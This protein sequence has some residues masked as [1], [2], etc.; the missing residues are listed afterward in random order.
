MSERLSLPVSEIGER[1]GAL[2]L[3]KPAAVAAMASSLRHY[4]QLS[5]VVVCPHLAEG[6]EL[7]DGFKRL[8][9][10]RRMTELT[11]LQARVLR[12]D[13]R[14]A[15]A[16]VVELNRTGGRL[17]EFEEALVVQSLYR[18]DG[19]TQTEIGV[20][21]GRGASWVSR[22]LGL[23]ERL[24]DELKEQWRLGLVNPTQAREL[25]RL[26]RGKQLEVLDAVREQGLPTRQVTALVDQLLAARPQQQARILA[27]PQAALPEQRE[28]RAERSDA[29]LSRAGNLCR[30][31]LEALVHSCLQVCRDCSQSGLSRLEPGDGLV[32][33][34]YLAPARQ[35]TTAAMSVLDAAQCFVRQDDELDVSQP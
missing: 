13:V 32:L 33:E 2:R 25:I 7:V 1:Y 10:A 17:S 11:H 9:A 28:S 35:A 29:R 23:V 6:F 19:L 31:S 27:N 8:H 26:P 3:T 15:K 22:R 16:A 30:R 12:I 14:A 24:A 20:L 18:D 4:G 5:S 34:Q 21:L